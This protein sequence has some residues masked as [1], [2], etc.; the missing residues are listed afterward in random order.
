MHFSARL[1]ALVAVLV[2]CAACAHSLSQTP[3]PTTAPSATIS[4]SA[5]A[6][7]TAAAT[8]TSAIDPVSGLPFVN[9]ADL[10][11]EAADTVAVI[12]AD[13]PFPYSQDGVVFQNRE[14][15]LPAEPTGYYHEYTV[16]TPGSPDRG[17]RRI[18][19]GSDGAMYYTG[20]HYAS[21][22]RIRDD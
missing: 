14:G 10:P 8:P 2:M 22:E 9:L 12:Q 17:A 19:T 4:A 11:P 18:V 1:A 13:G 3:A 16:K 20:D 15:V 6:A 5:T 21:F 7:A